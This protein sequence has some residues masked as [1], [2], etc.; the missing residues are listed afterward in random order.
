MR[1]MA[2]RVP[3]SP[4]ASGAGSGGGVALSSINAT[5][6]Q[7]RWSRWGVSVAC[8][9]SLERGAWAEQ[10]GYNFTHGHSELRPDAAL[11][12]AV[13]LRPAEEIGHEGTECGAAV[14]ELNHA[15]C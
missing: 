1:T 14:Y 8:R 2:S 15:R 7:G 11:E 9:Y 10:A 5:H 13:I 3:V 4:G 6:V 12:A